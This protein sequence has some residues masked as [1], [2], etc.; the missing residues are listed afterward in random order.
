MKTLKTIF[1]SALLLLIGSTAMAQPSAAQVKKDVSKT[2]PGAI[3]IEVVG[4]GETT[5]EWEGST[6]MFYHRRRVKVF[7]KTSFADLLPDSRAISE[8]L[9][10][11]VK[12]GGTF[13]Y[14][15]YNPGTSELTGMPPIDIDKINQFI[16][17]NIDEVINNCN[18][19]IGEP[20][21]RIEMTPESKV[22]WYSLNSFSFKIDTV[23]MRTRRNE[24]VVDLARGEAN[25][26][27]YRDDINGDW[28]R[29]LKGSGFTHIE[30]VK[31]ETYS[32]EELDSWK[33]IDQYY[34]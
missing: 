12:Q 15:K 5:E 7:G 3:T 22:T 23:M 32:K 24:T 1:A 6:K 21:T 27:F 16:A 11:Y 14:K 18:R 28:V 9:A 25:I 30:D 26:R 17:K 8:G 31:K 19:R 4:N 33:T 29:V 2:F 13:V 34:R 10:V 20:L